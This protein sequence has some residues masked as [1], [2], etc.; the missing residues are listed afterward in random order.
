MAITTFVETLSNILDVGSINRFFN[1]N[2]KITEKVL[3]SIRPEGQVDGNRFKMASLD[4]GQ[5]KSW[6]YNLQN[7][8]WGDWGKGNAQGGAGLVS[9]VA[10]SQ[11]CSASQAVKWLVDKEFLDSKSAKKTLQADDGDPLVF[12]IPDEH[13]PWEYVREQNFIKRDRA[14]IDPERLWTFRDT[15]GTLLG[16]KYRIDDRRNSKELFTLTY[17]AESGWG[18]KAWDKNFVPPY[19]LEQLGDGSPTVRILFVEGEKAKD[20]AQQILGQRWKVL[21][22][23]GVT[24]SNKLWLP[25]DEFWSDCEVVIWPDHDAAGRDSARAIQLLVQKL[26][27]KPREVRM[28]R[29]ESLGNL[30]PKWDLGD[31]QEGGIDVAEALETAEEV[32]SF[33]AVSREWIYVGQQDSFYNLTDRSLVYTATS[34]DRMYAR[35]KDKRSP[36]QKFLEDNNTLRASDVDF[37]PGE[38]PLIDAPNGKSFLNEWYA[39]ENYS[40]AQRIARDQSISDEEIADKAKYFIQHLYRLTG[41][42]IVEPDFDFE[43]GEPDK[44]T[45]G[46]TA[47]D[48]LAWHLSELVKRPM[49]KRG[50]ILM[51]VSAENGTGK[52]YMRRMMQAVLGATRSRTITVSELLGDYHDWADGL[53]FYEL[54]EVKSN[55]STEVYEELKKRHS[56]QPFSPSMLKDRTQN[57]QLLNIKTKAKKAQRDFLNGCITSNDLFPLAL[58]NTSGQEGSDRRLYVLNPRTVLTQ[59]QTEE[60]FDDE[61]MHRAAWIGAWLMRY[62]PEFKWNPSWA[63]V[64]AHKRLMLEKDKTRSENRSDKYELGRFDEFYH[65]VRWAIA[66]KVGALSK[67][68]FSSDQ[69]RSIC[70]ANR[71]KFP[72]DAVKFE[73]ILAKAGVLKGPSLRID[74]RQRVLFT[75]DKEWLSKPNDAWKE[76]F[77]KSFNGPDDEM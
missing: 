13:Q 48:A 50:W 21:S 37:V 67:Q 53:L 65:V 29:P 75:V 46:R 24:A 5:G 35:Y 70:E 43:A 15:D 9:F 72:F 38:G 14:L 25:D 31:W 59:R 36:S 60:L 8:Q 69:I 40:E 51:M 32:D 39:T 2:R 55:E 57:T 74:G 54:G 4:G 49:D 27:N 18:K 62:R 19:G 64:T 12:P 33:E 30:P 61:L 28:I 26:T 58:A 3:R 73:A 56:Y 63:P 42:E 6:D 11:R 22:Y 47:F 23:S 41:G 44:T 1:T 52:T 17:R 66:E 16:Y 68:V 76:E 7:G 20:K 71:V 10:A 34:F 77:R 45:E